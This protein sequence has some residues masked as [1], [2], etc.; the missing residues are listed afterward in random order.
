MEKKVTSSFEKNEYLNEH[1][2]LQKGTNNNNFVLPFVI[3]LIHNYLIINDI[4]SPVRT[5]NKNLSL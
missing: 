3:T 4:S 1:L 2:I 5:A